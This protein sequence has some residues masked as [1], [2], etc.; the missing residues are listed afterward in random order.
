METFALEEVAH[1][2]EDAL[3]LGTI[4]FD[5]V[6]HLRLFFRPDRE[7]PKREVEEFSLPENETLEEVR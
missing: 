1:A 4:S 6:R 7:G 3:L 2:I 5:A